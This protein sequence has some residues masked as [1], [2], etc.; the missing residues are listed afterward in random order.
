MYVNWPLILLIAIIVVGLW[1][2]VRRRVP[3]KPNLAVAIGLLNNISFNQ[4]LIDDFEKNGQSK[5]KFKVYNWQINKGKMQFLDPDLITKINETFSLTIEYNSR[6]STG[7]KDDSTV[8][9]TNI[10]LENL[11]TALANIK[12]PLIEWLK[13]D[14]D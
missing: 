8:L 7:K 2:F 9:F 4:K 12:T 11:K 14:L 6:I 10:E 1:V 13:E 3:H 5:K